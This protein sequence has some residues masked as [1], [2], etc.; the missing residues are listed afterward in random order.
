M[1]KPLSRY[2]AA[3]FFIAFIRD[4]RVRRKDEQRDEAEKRSNILQ[5][6]NRYQGEIKF[7]HFKTQQR[8]W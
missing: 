8:L 5:K 4:K 1:N 2:A 7:Y 3:Y 6:E